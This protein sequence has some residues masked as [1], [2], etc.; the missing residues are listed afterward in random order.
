M[1]VETRLRSAITTALAM[2]ALGRRCRGGGA[3]GS[4]S[5]LL[6]DGLEL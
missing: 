6:A 2:V 1:T 3:I 4:G 5:A